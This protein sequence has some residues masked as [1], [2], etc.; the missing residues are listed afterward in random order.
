V[1]K[2]W[3]KTRGR[4]GITRVNILPVGNQNIIFNFPR[5]QL[6][7]TLFSGTQHREWEHFTSAF[8]REVTPFSPS[9]SFL[10]HRVRA[11]VSK[12]QVISEV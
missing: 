9:I 4:R 6:G 10:S 8:P 1:S 7:L 5:E 11:R 12:A 3:T 2:R